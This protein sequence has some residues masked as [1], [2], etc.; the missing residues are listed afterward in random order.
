MNL[1]RYIGIPYASKGRGFDGC[2]CWG[3]VHLFY[4]D[5]LGINLPRYDEAYTDAAELAET[6]RAVEEGRSG[7]K[8]V[9]TPKLGDAVLIRIR[10][11]PV[12]VGVYVGDG[13]M[14]HVR[15]GTNAN[16]QKLSAPFWKQS[17]EGFYRHV[18]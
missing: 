2:D 14:L 18:G 1:T 6:K 3:L 11:E 13:L 5:E 12:H 9:E 15:K 8:R 10:G 4:H 7:W 16:L 17:L